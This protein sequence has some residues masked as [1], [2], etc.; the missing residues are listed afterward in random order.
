[1]T[2][3]ILTSIKIGRKEY[4]IKKG[5]YVLYNGSTYLFCSGD[6]RTLKFERFDQYRHLRI[7][8]SVLKLIPFDKMEKQPYKSTYIE[9][10]VIWLF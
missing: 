7:P 3:H 4:P 1:M 10:A 5:D 8:N 6:D 9:D 2:S